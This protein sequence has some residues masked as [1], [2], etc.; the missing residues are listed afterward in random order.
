MNAV[1]ARVIV[2]RTRFHAQDQNLM[3]AQIN[4]LRYRWRLRAGV[5]CRLHQRPE[6]D[7][8]EDIDVAVQILAV[9][10]DQQITWTRGKRVEVS[11]CPRIAQV[12]SSNPSVDVGR[13]D[14]RR[15]T[16]IGGLAAN[17][18]RKQARKKQQERRESDPNQLHKKRSDPADAL[19]R[20]DQ[21]AL[22]GLDYQI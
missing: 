16:L 6:S 17:T 20:A 13:Q 4:T 12:E 19:P 15:E 9:N 22:I 18:L 5:Q 11:R 10:G 7:R 3:C 14:G 8:R 1:R 21:P 2:W